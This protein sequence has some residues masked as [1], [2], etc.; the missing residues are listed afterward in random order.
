[1]P[2][3]ASTARTTLII[4]TAVVAA[5]ACLLIGGVVMALAMGD[6]IGFMRG[7]TD[8]ADQTPFVTDERSV[9]I[10][11]TDFT[12]SPADLTVE[13]G[14]EVTWINEDSAVH[15][16][17][18]RGEDWATELLSKGDSQAIVFET[19]GTFDYFCT[20]HPWME[21]TITVR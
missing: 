16:A 14:T 8:T 5:S 10:T 13:A 17:T 12:F 11:I 9:T 18:D 19:P 4:A 1:M 21:G 20:I 6:H 3:S 15:D 2:D 7:S